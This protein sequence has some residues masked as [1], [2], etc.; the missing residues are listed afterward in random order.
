MLRR[1]FPNLFNEGV[2]GSSSL[3]RIDQGGRFYFLVVSSTFRKHDL[4]YFGSTCSNSRAGVSDLILERQSVNAGQGRK[5]KPEA[6]VRCM[7]ELGRGNIHLPGRWKAMRMAMTDR[8]SLFLGGILSPD[9][10]IP[11]YE[12]V[13]LPHPHG[14]HAV[15]TSTHGN[16]WISFSTSL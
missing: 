13:H 16:I 6:L 14:R 4:T 1:K 9:H 12:Y 7:L 8:Q 2:S 10:T 3:H 15:K 11:E 5:P